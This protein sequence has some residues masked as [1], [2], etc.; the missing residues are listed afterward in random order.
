[1]ERTS[2]CGMTFFV[3]CHDTRLYLL[4]G[5]SHKLVRVP[6]WFFRRMQQ[7]AFERQETVF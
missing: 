7:R 2:L 3:G 6:Y 5:I 4:D 1:M